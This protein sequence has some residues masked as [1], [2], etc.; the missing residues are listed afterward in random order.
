M[1]LHRKQGTLLIVLSVMLV[2]TCAT[3]GR[4]EFNSCSQETLKGDYGFTIT[5]QILSGPAAGPVTG[6]AKTH[7]DG[8]GNLQQ[9]DHVVHNGN[10]PAV[11]WRPGTGTYTVNDDCTGA[12][13]INFTDGSPSLNLRF[14][15][16]REGAE[17]HTVV[18]NP[19]TAITS[20]GLKP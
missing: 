13:Q 20:I 6:V 5:G 17:I 4:A 2:S 16:V 3:I 12:A 7:F 11:D 19:G 10:L 8:E 14:V 1:D 15:L 9:V 18:S